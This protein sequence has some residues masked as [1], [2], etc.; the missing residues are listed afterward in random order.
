MLNLLIDSGNTFTKI[1]IFGNNDIINTYQYSSLQINDIKALKQEYPK[2]INCIL[3]SV[4]IIDKELIDYLQSEF[5][6][7]INLDYKTKSPVENLYSTKKTLGA[8]RI[9]LIVGANNIYPNADVLVIDLGSAI[10]YDFINSN[11]KYLGG[12]ISPGLS[13]RF[14][15]LNKLTKKLP[16]LNK[17]ENVSLIPNNTEDA[18]IS[19]VQNGIIYEIE[20]Y[21]ND[22]KKRFNDIKVLISGGDAIFFKSK[23]NFTIFAY[24]NLIFYG[25][26]RIIEYNAKD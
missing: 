25:L 23:L 7:F 5:N 14:I 26:N 18:I 19:G 16:L 3:S 12:T 15:A 6:R 11:N 21:I 1:A 2:L 22:Y 17:S 24:P 10:T 9:A 13:M 4:T 8:D 20:G